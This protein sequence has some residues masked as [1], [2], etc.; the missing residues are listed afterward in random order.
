MMIKK[1]LCF[2]LACACVANVSAQP[3]RR[4]GAV[5]ADG[6]A[7]VAK[8]REAKVTIDIPARPGGMCLASAPNLQANGKLLPPIG[9]RP[10]QWIVLESKYT[11]YVKWQ[12][13]LTFTWHVLLDSSKAKEKDTANLPAPYSY[14]TA[15]VRYVDIK[16][17]SHMT[18]VCLPPSVPER[19]GEPCTI[20]LVITNKEGDE[21]ANHTE[22]MDKNAATAMQKA[23]G[24]WWECDEFMSWTKKDK[25]SGTMKPVVERRQGLVDRSKTPFWLVNNADYEMV[26]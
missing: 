22:N 12:D 4:R 8:G 7:A 9:G 1:A 20:S 14:Y 16:K 18:S 11:T 13:E 17:G 25:A 24:K 21:L 26:Q 15:Q 10:R 23:N 3:L 5:G 6:G 2:A 19:F